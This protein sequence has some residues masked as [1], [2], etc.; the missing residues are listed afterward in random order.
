MEYKIF[1]FE[2]SQELIRSNLFTSNFKDNDNSIVIVNNY[3]EEN[4]NISLKS[5]VDFYFLTRNT[6]L[7]CKIDLTFEKPHISS[8]LRQIALTRKN[9]VFNCEVSILHNAK[10]TKCDYQFL[11]FA[12]DDSSLK[13]KAKN[14]I[15]NGMKQSATRQGLKILTDGNAKAVG[16]P[17]LMIEEFDVTASHGNS[18]GQID[19]KQIYYLQSKGIEQKVAKWMT[20]KANVISILK[21][22]DEKIRD[23]IIDILKVYYE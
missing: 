22:C 6:N 11:G 21:D 16:Q 9:E 2:T 15:L 4:L 18:I 14:K 20:I 7:D 12:F 10:D 17:G 13:I 19:K 8:T 3:N 1:S 23:S 5:N